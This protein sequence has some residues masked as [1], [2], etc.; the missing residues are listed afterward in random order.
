[1]WASELGMDWRRTR[2]SLHHVLL[3]LHQL[4]DARGL[5]FLDVVDEFPLL[6]LLPLVDYVDS[7]ALRRA[8]YSSQA[9]ASALETQARGRLPRSSQNGVD[10]TRGLILLPGDSA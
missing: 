9:G 3:L 7:Y 10:Q 4:A 2:S 8:R 1:V 6:I 5:V